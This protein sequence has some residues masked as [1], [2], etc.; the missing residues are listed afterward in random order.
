[1]AHHR[2]GQRRLARAVRPHQRVDLAAIDG[3]IDAAQDVLLPGSDVKV[4]YL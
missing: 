1:M 2:V 3:Q 4:S